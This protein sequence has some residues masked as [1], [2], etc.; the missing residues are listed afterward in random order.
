M[1]AFGGSGGPRQRRGLAIIVPAARMSE[2]PRAF[3][4]F[5][6][7]MGG[8]RFLEH[9][10]AREP[11]SPQYSPRCPTTWEATG[12]GPPVHVSTCITL[13]RVRSSDIIDVVWK[14]SLAPGVRE[15]T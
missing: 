12:E 3:P 2:E 11:P 7:D 4:L 6:A 8:R 14:H 5:H 13:E 10:D 15:V 9:R 1:F